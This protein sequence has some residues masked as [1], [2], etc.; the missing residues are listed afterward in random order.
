MYTALAVIGMF[1]FFFSSSKLDT[2]AINL[3]MKPPYIL[4]RL[5]LWF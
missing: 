3:T 2:F 4:T 5:A 1:S